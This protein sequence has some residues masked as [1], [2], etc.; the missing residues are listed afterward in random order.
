MKDSN[1]K[2]KDKK[3]IAKTKPKK[4][5]S[6]FSQFVKQKEV[7]EKERGEINKKMN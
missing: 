2:S 4:L 7:D 6:K 1:E 5:N 3:K